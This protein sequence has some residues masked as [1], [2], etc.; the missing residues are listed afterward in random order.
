[1]DNLQKRYGLEYSTLGT[2]KS[3]DGPRCRA[4]RWIPSAIFAA[5]ALMLAAPL[6]TTA[7]AA[8]TDAIRLE[9]DV[10]PAPDGN[11]PVTAKYVTAKPT[12]LYISF[13]LWGG[14]VRDVHLNA[15]EP[16]EVL[17]KPKGYDWLLVGKNGAGIG[18]VPMSALAPAR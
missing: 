12:D 18:Y 13:F 10:V 7:Q 14:K 11:E 6:A 16:V 1:M 2:R 9:N 8:N 15:G 4:R 17:A 3:T 5:L